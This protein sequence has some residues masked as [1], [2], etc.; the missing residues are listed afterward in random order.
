MGIIDIGK[1]PVGSQGRA[2]GSVR[3]IMLRKK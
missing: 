2:S 3:R 1:E